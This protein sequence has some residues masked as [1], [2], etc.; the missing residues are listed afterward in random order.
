MSSVNTSS[1]GK[2][3]D[4]SH[5]R[6]AVADSSAT[7]ARPAAP[8]PSPLKQLRRRVIEMTESAFLEFMHASLSSGRDQDA[9]RVLVSVM[10]EERRDY[11]K[12]CMA[13][14]SEAANKIF[15]YKM[16]HDVSTLTR[17]QKMQ[18]TTSDDGP[19]LLEAT[20]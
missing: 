13:Y 9:Q 18:F 15:N 4:N 7:P 2:E 14:G 6:N 1:E 17:R 12:D 8:P 10:V 11:L 16:E 5:I 19:L 3:D 20:F